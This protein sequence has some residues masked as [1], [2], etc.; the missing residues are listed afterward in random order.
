[1]LPAQINNNELFALMADKSL[2]RLSDLPA[3]VEWIGDMPT[4]VRG[5]IWYYSKSMEIV[6]GEFF[7]QFH[8]LSPLFRQFLEDEHFI[9]AGESICDRVRGGRAYSP[10]IEIFTV[11]LGPE[12]EARIM[13]FIRDVRNYIADSA[14][15]FNLSIY[16]TPECIIMLV[17]PN[18]LE[19]R[20]I[21]RTYESVA[22]VIH[23]FD[24]APAAIALVNT[25]GEFNV[26]M[27]PLAGF[28]LKTNSFPVDPTRQHA[29]FE[30][31]IKLYNCVKD[32][33]II[34]P[35]MDPAALS[36]LHVRFNK[37]TLNRIKPGVGAEFSAYYR[38][39]TSTNAFMEA[40]IYMNINTSVHVD[41]SIT[42]KSDTN[43][44]LFNV[45]QLM[46]ERDWLISECDWLISSTPNWQIF[47]N[48][49]TVDA[50][51]YDYL[52]VAKSD[53]ATAA[54]DFATAKLDFA[55][56]KSDFA[57]P[58]S[59]ESALVH[60]IAH[61]IRRS[62]RHRDSI[63]QMFGDDGLV[64]RIMT[65]NREFECHKQFDCDSLEIAREIA[66]I[67]TARAEIGQRFTWGEYKDK[68]ECADLRDYY[69][70]YYRPETT[71]VKSAAKLS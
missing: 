36:N 45:I 16:R 21:T 39:N 22:Q 66:S 51:S 68:L 46:N 27:T 70:S 11:G 24:I 31:R 38:L 3:K 4:L 52:A 60:L 49:K 8:I 13:A 53:F 17:G 48:P 41:T 37:F 67:V 47:L 56:A 33:N 54:S 30:T 64:E 40:D 19:I 29:S 65:L 5:V 62:S 32:F 2:M 71:L 26:L 58:I 43:I 18:N 1:M 14:G 23:S 55:T 28:A 57:T 15:R 42:Y 69:G 25:G 50:K 10:P 20:F 7:E 61:H 34:F 35:H 6:I 12:A 59:K 44:C 63:K 9:V